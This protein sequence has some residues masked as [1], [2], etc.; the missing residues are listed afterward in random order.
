MLHALLDVRHPVDDE[1]V[2]P[3]DVNDDRGVD[4][5]A[6]LERHAQHAPVPADGDDL[7]VEQ[8]LAALGLGGA[9]KVV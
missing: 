1:G 7:P 5:L 3:G 9:L 4:L 2:R 6:V 8:V